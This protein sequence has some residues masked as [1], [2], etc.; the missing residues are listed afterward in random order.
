[1]PITDNTAESYGLFR[2]EVFSKTDVGKIDGVEEDFKAGP[3]LW[4]ATALLDDFVVLDSNAPYGYVTDLIFDDSSRLLSVVAN[5]ASRDLGI[6]DV[7]AFPWQHYAGRHRSTTTR[8]RTT[9]KRSSA[10]RRSTTRCPSDAVEERIARA[11][12]REPVHLSQVLCAAIHQTARA[13]LDGIVSRLH[14]FADDY[15]V[16]ASQ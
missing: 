3:R 1:V 14:E 7:Y 2:E 13:A 10:C 8:C 11:M 16:A 15:R 9:R 5:S 4:K 6:Y 12:G